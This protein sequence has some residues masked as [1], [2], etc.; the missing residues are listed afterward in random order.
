MIADIKPGMTG[1]EVDRIGRTVIEEAGFPT[2]RHSVGHQIGREVHDGGT[3]LG[4]QRV[5]ARPAVEGILT[6]GEVY[7]IEPTVIQDDGQASCIVEEN[8]VLGSSEVTVLSRPQLTLYVV[9]RS[10]DGE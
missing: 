5:P 2:I 3:V 1:Y 9:A 7:A 4:P 8:V 6:E 10:E